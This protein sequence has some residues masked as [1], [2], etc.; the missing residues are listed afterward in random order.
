MVF[1]LLTGEHLF[2]AWF[3]PG[4]DSFQDDEH[5]L[6]LYERFGSLPDELYQ[7]WDSSSLYFT[8]ERKLYNC[9]LGGVEDGEEPLMLEQ[10]TM[11]GAVNRGARG[12][13]SKEKRQVKGLLRWVLQ[14]DP[15]KRPSA[16]EI[17][18]HPW[19]SDQSNG[20]TTGS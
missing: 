6:S 19:F 12:L 5:L 14:F 10:V 17:L 15:A 20:S 4:D 3:H 16:A 13:S 11:E 2:T 8:P 7:L 1:E 18:R 9:A